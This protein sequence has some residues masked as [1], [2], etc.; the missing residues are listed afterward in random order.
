MIT[1]KLT[2]LFPV[3]FQSNG[4]ETNATITAMSYHIRTSVTT[5]FN[6]VSLINSHRY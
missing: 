6:E 1:Y 5:Q 3:I 4:V 2:N